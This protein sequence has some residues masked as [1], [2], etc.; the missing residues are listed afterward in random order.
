M[1]NIPGVKAE[2]VK[3]VHVLGF[4]SASPS[5]DGKAAMIVLEVAGK[6]SGSTRKF[7]ITCA[8]ELLPLLRA[9]FHGALAQLPPQHIGTETFMFHTVGPQGA[10]QVD[11]SL[12]D[13]AQ[14]PIMLR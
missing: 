3:S 13:N 8:V 1:Q 4:V 6:A 5:T 2:T 11:V 10:E 7:A 12:S 9:A 14:F